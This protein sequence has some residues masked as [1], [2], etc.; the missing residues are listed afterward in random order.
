[1]IRIA[2]NRGNNSSIKRVKVR[3]PGVILGGLLVLGLVLTLPAFAE[4][5]IVKDQDGAEVNDP[6]MVFG[7]IARAWEDG[8]QQTLADLVHEGGLKVT[9]GGTADRT[10]HYSPSQAF[11]YF[12]NMFQTHR[13]LIFIFEKMQDASAG[14]RV[15]GMVVWKRR[16][17]DSER[18]QELKLFC[19]LARQGD[20]WRLV[21]I[22]KIR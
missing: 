18:I 8:D 7:M 13:T 2:D 10:T 5:G 1:M 15:H 14:D 4:A 3:P 6:R 17:P 12:K 11:Y 22:N 16:R 21:E 20:Q 19:V 9:T